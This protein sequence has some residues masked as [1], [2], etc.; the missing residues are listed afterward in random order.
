MTTATIPPQQVDIHD[1]LPQA[2]PFVLVDRLTAWER[3]RAATV[4][5][6]H[7]GI[8]LLEGD[9]LP[10]CALVEVIAQTCAASIGYYHKYVLH[11]PIKL[12][13]IG[14]ISDLTTSRDIRRGETLSTT[15]TVLE[16]AMGLSLVEATV[17][18]GDEVVAHGNMKIALSDIEK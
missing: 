3:D 15:I 9:T 5:T 6:V 4:L 8:P 17:T 11:V 10:A 2:E 14:A 13:Y 16:R 12:G 1:I 18:A 7:E